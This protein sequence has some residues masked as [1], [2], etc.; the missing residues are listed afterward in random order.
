VYIFL[1]DPPPRPGG[2]AKI[3][4][5][6]MLGK[7]IMEKGMKKKGGECKFFPRLLKVC[8]WYFFP[9]WLKMYKIAQKKGWKFFPYGANH[10]NEISFGSKNINKEG[11]KKWILNLI[12]TPGL[13]F[14]LFLQTFIFKN[15]LF[16]CTFPLPIIV[17]T[18]MFFPSNA[19][20]AY[21]R[22]PH[23]PGGPFSSIFLM[24]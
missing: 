19:I 16:T 8:I 13:G 2:G 9:N 18:S 6:N 4:P 14:S 11:A 5:N 23:C 15:A 7:K 21:K 12:Y 10:L 1:F 24:R 3:W 17:F 20:N 22:D